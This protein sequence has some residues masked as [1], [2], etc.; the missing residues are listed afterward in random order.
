M[1]IRFYSQDWDI[2]DNRS[3]T[4][5]VKSTPTSIKAQVSNSQRSSLELETRPDPSIQSMDK[6]RRKTFYNKK[7]CSYIP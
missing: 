6:V 1:Y 4:F 7:I 3:I 5:E 2:L